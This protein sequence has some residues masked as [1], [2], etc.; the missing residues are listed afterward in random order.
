MKKIFLTIAAIC[1]CFVLKAQTFTCDG[2]NYNVTGDQTVTI[3]GHTADFSA[4]DFEV[5]SSVTNEDTEYNVTGIGTFAF[6]DCTSLTGTLTIPDGIKTI[7]YNAFYGCNNL[8]GSLTI[9]GSVETIG[10]AAFAYCTGFDGTLTLPGNIKLDNFAFAY[11]SGF[12]GDLYIPQMVE[13]GPSAFQYCTGFT[14]SLTIGEFVSI[15]PQAFTGCTG[16]IGTLTI[17]RFITSIEESAFR[18]CSGFTN[19]TIGNEVLYI[20]K[21]AFQGCSGFRCPLTIP[22]SVK[23]IGAFAFRNC[24]GF[25]GT[26]T[27][28]QNME[29]IGDD[30]FIGC[31]KLVEVVNHSALNVEKGSTDNGYAAY[32]AISVKNDGTPTPLD[33]VDG[34][35]FFTAD[36]INY[37]ISYEGSATQLT[38][39][40]SYYEHDYVIHDY[41]FCGSNIFTQSLTIPSSVKRIGKSAFEGCS[42]FTGSLN[43][44]EVQNIGESAFKNCGFTGTLTIPTSVTSI[45]NSAFEGC[46][47]FEGPL[48]IPASVT[49]IGESAFEG[50]SGFTGTL[51]LP[52]SLTSISQGT[53]KN[54]R[55]TGQLTIPETVTKIGGS[56]FNGCSGLTGPLTI[57]SS[58][59]EIGFLAFNGCTGF[60]GDLVIPNSVTEI[61]RGAFS[62]CTGFEGTLT[63]GTSVTYIGDEAFL[64]C[65][66]LKGQ[67]TIPN[68]V[69]YIGISAFSR[70]SGLTGSLTIPD[71]VT[72]IESFAFDGCTGLIDILTIGSSV[73]DIG[74]NAFSNT[75]F[76]QIV[77]KPLTPVNF[78]YF[79][80]TLS[81]FYQTHV[82]TLTVPCDRREAY[83]STGWGSISHDLT[84]RET[85]LFTFNVSSSNDNYGCVEHTTK[86]TDCKDTEATVT[87]TPYLNYIFLNW[88][89]NGEYASSDNPYTF[90]MKDADSDMDIVANFAE[91]RDYVYEPVTSIPDAPNPDAVYV[92][93][94][95]IDENYF[96]HA[97]GSEGGEMTLASNPENPV[98]YS[99]SVP[100]TGYCLAQCNGGYLAVSESGVSLLGEPDNCHLTIQNGNISSVAAPNYTIFHDGYI[101]KSH[102]G[103]NEGNLCFFERKTIYQVFVSSSPVEAGTATA[104]CGDETI[105]TAPAG[106]T[107]TL[108]ATPYGSNEFTGWTE[109]G[110]LVS[111][112][113]PFVFIL[114]DD[115]DFVANFSITGQYDFTAECSTGQT[116]YYKIIDAANRKVRIV[117]PRSNDEDGWDGYT[118]PSGDIVLP[119]TVTNEGISYIVCEIGNYAFNEC[120]GL[121]GSLTIPSTVT[122]IGESA[123]LRC[124]GFTGTL[125]IPN[126]VTS[127]GEY[128]FFLCN[129]L[130]GELTIPNSVTEIGMWAFY[131]C[132]GFSGTLILGNSLE[133]IG[134]Y[135]FYDCTF[136]KIVSKAQTAPGLTQEIPDA[137]YEVY[138]PSGSTTSYQSE[139]QGYGYTFIEKAMT[140][141]FTGTGH[142]WNTAASWTENAVPSQSYHDV[143][144]RSNCELTA[145]AMVCN[146]NV[147]LGKTLTI[148]AGQTLTATS[149]TLEDGTQL[150]NNGTVACNDVCMNKDIAGY[151]T[152]TGRWYLVSSPVKAYVQT[153]YMTIGDYDLYRFSQSGDDH[154]NEWLNYKAEAFQMENQNGYLYA[155]MDYTTLTFKG[156]LAAPTAKTLDYVE[157]AQFAGFNLI[158]N[159]YTCDAYLADG[160]SFY[161]MNDAGTELIV[162]NDHPAIAPCEGIFVQAHNTDESVTFS[163][164][165]TRSL[166]V[167]SVVLTLS[168]RFNAAIDRAIVHLGEGDELGKLMLNANG[169]KLYIP[170]DDKDYAVIS[171]NSACGE[172]PVNFKAASDGTYTINV[173]TNNVDAQYLHLID[174]MTGNDT[175]L[176]VTDSYS[177][178]AKTSD[179]ASRFKLVFGVKDETS[180]DSVS[181]FAYISN[182]EI[183]INNEG[184]SILQVID[185]MGRIISSQEIEGECRISTEDMT[186]GVYV[187]NLNGLTQKIVVK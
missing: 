60:S 182:G 174:N 95:N 3:T 59:T 25:T 77:A 160:R 36:D 26:L 163:T 89:V 11:C 47:G 75:N 98:E 105:Q 169:T 34:F 54:C 6:E 122:S 4:H 140:Y 37:L 181:N 52:N 168:Q 68:S 158:G 116:L 81:P 112:D 20:K 31:R 146:V 24:T 65:S 5:P 179:Y 154:G 63:I 135:A 117:A 78:D 71:S 22:N 111:T 62:D 53:F 27:L 61:Q 129:H 14:G 80:E 162:D 96:L 93:G 94:Y 143:V 148:N 176:L 156:R 127:I 83:A 178:E 70:C 172:M 41:A 161:R 79:T 74:I 187:L 87:A 42:C 126:S 66:N 164:S 170:Q 115:R 180:T 29:G 67:L 102:T 186:A 88:T 10:F 82:E 152:G 183:I 113:N 86:P 147:T 44:N 108:T 33:V 15:G 171:T 48:T 35:T 155:N 2:L 49:S 109:H 16:F 64:A 40:E 175:D 101:I 124:S 55:F 144:I 177:F 46:S 32:Y 84:I 151:G 125:T 76:I 121:T 123:F 23:T 134:S 131:Y 43:L 136:N 8:T 56:A 110:E 39:P 149:I 166:P 9:P 100:E 18:D 141:H 92:L 50:C 139:W 57:P 185:M 38:L 73:N 128:A 58:V 165:D 72:T 167:G 12:T 120:T 114:E 145:N 138:I 130:T 107:I 132:Q 133:S 45:G 142:D 69:I 7:G 21:K 119:E 153:S 184:R 28:G 91:Q 97:S 17:G 137:T 103:T 13:I 150:L 159:P 90:D 30:A 99:L 51:S 19:L 85:L 1:C 173:N 118:K 157:G 104:T 106:S